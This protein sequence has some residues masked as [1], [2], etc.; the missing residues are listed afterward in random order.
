M[1]MER[2]AIIADARLLI[3]WAAQELNRTERGALEAFVADIPLAHVAPGLGVTRGG[4]WM[5]R[6]SALRKMRARL[7]LAG[8]TSTSD[9]IGS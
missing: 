3:R 2:S 4:V 5:A 7:A 1:N 6:E 9:L 8:I